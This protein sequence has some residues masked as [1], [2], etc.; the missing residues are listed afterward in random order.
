MPCFSRISTQTQSIIFDKLTVE[1]LFKEFEQ[2]RNNKFEDKIGEKE[3]PS[4]ID[5]LIILKIQSILRM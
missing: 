2:N 4:D 5:E 1:I 3:K